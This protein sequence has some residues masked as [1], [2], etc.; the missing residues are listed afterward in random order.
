ME[1]SKQELSAYNLKVLSTG[2][3]IVNFIAFDLQF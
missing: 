3:E 1:I 2:M